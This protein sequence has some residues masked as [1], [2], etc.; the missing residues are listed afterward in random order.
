MFIDINGIEELRKHTLNE[1]EIVLG[2]N[3]NLTETMEILTNASTKNG[4]EYCSN[5]MKH[6][7][8]VANV[9]V[10]NAGTIAGNLSIK[11]AHNEFP[12][13]IFLILESVGAMLAIA[14]TVNK[15]TTVSV[16]EY[17]KVDMNKK[18]LL[19]VTLPRL[20]PTQYI[21]RS[22]KIM[23][24]AQNAHAYVNAGFLLKLDQNKVV[25]ARI[26]FGGISPTFIHA[27]ATE[28]QI[29][30][31]ELHSNETLQATLDSLANEINPDSVLP[32]ASPAYRKQLALALFYKFILSTCPKDKQTPSNASGGEIIQRTLSSGIQNFDTKKDNYPLTQPVVKREGLVQCSGEAQYVNDL[33][34]Q[35]DELWA[36]FVQTDRPHAK[37]GKIDPSEALVSK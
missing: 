33:P 29:L 7:D 37:I 30:G 21:Y 24:R 9:P 15:T 13:D 16:A 11:H 31:Q 23:L 8:L 14:E 4:F 17:L 20:D 34:Y 36:A 18:V 35:K 28:T 27:S 6:I 1:N 19:S 26:C 22:Y 3:I 12:S 25:S 10:R 5:L 32:D 2:A